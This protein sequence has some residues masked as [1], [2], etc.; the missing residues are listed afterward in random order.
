MGYV[1]LKVDG[2]REAAKHAGNLGNCVRDAQQIDDTHNVKGPFGPLCDKKKSMKKRKF[3][4]STYPQPP[5]KK[6]KRL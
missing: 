3:H 5:H 2:T 1:V 4:P 6:K